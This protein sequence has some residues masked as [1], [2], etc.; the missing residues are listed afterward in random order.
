VV[1]FVVPMRSG[2]PPSLLELREHAAERIA[3]FKSPREVVVMTHIP[4]TA[5]GKIRRTALPR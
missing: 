4:R 5:S 1:A 2:D 3:R